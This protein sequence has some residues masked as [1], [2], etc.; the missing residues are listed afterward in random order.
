MRGKKRDEERDESWD[1]GVTGGLDV[2]SD[3]M[4]LM[5][6]PKATGTAEAQRLR[7]SGWVKGWVKGWVRGRDKGR[8]KG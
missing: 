4:S 3:R 1:G 6:A 8:K 2:P 7:A 5:S